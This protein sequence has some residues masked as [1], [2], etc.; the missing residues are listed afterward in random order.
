MGKVIGINSGIVGVAGAAEVAP[1]VAGTVLQHPD[2][3]VTGSKAAGD[4]A[5]GYFDP[6]PPPPSVS[7][8]A[9][10]G[11]RWIYNK[12]KGQNKEL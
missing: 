5:S 2:K 10:S 9:G 7:G 11:S 8:H 12:Y 4:F 6:G 3:I 1:S